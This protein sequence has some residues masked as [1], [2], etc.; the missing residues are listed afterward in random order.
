M[1]KIKKING[2]LIVRFNDRERGDYP[3]LGT[4]GVIDAEL[5]TGHMDIDRGA[6]EYEDADCIEAA[7]EQARGLESELDAD[8][9]PATYTI[10]KETDTTTEEN[11]ADPQMMIAGWETQ[12]ARQV[13][14]R[15]YPDIDQRTAAHEL[16]GFKVALERL[17]LI[18]DEDCFV[19]P[20]AFKPKPGEDFIH[21]PEGA[22]TRQTFALGQELIAACPPNDCIVFRNT[23][24][25]CLDLDE[26]IDRVTGL[27]RRT[28]EAQLFKYQHE[29]FRMYVHNYALGEYRKERREKKEITATISPH[30]SGDGG[31]LTMPLRS[32]VPNPRS[33]DWKLISCPICG[34]ECWES[35]LARE[36][37]EAEPNLRAACTLCALKEGLQ[38]KTEPPEER[39]APRT[40]ADALERHLRRQTEIHDETRRIL[41]SLVKETPHEFK[42]DSG[43]GYS[44]E[45]FTG[46]QNKR[47]MQ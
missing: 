1:R 14:S 9:P 36:A 6:F 20:D 28:L 17:G 5:Y 29:L 23:F 43:S 34:A 18:E 27:A 44:A 21:S 10:V 11:T 35:S 33:D 46:K 13:E 4:F 38:T 25:M 7:I 15:H 42:I 16:Y 12:L 39:T 30:R 31:I 8:E 41:D 47:S 3:D 32:N 45:A 37:M 2:Y 40:D 26:Q 19:K 22:P 24:E